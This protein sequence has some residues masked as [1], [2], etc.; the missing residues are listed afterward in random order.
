M[1]ISSDNC[2]G[3]LLNARNSAILSALMLLQLSACSSPLKYEP[4]AKNSES[5]DRP[6]GSIYQ[7]MQHSTDNGS[8]CGHQYRIK[9]GDT[10]SAIAEKC[11]V[12][13]SVLAE[14]NHIKRA[15]KIYVNQLLSIPG[16]SRIKKP[17]AEEQDFSQGLVSSQPKKIEHQRQ[18]ERNKQ[19]K[20]QS[21]EWQW[22]VAARHDYRMVKDAKGIRSL[23]IHGHLG[24]TVMA[25]ASGEVVYAANGIREFGNMVMIRHSDGVLSVYAHNQM[26]LVKDGDKV[27]QGEE[28]AL[29]GNSGMTAQTKLH[30]EAR[31]KG[32]KIDIQKFFRRTP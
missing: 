10:L 31:Y 21:G 7:S 26:L 5:H 19:Q 1:R 9:S 4:R 12:S 13:M 25:V 11:Q 28:I 23:E 24:E 22:P 32:R 30:L 6:T 29:L 15:D 14:I 27:Q 17:T 8:P 3:S 2:F 16:N 20:L 18:V